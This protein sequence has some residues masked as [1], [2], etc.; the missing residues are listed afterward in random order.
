MLGYIL[1]GVVVLAALYL[2][3][4]YNAL[5]KNKS[6]SNQTRSTVPP[7]TS[8]PPPGEPGGRARR[9]PVRG[10][11]LLTVMAAAR[12]RRRSAGTA[13]ARGRPARR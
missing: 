6:Q 9:G 10:K 13:R 3:Y 2:V 7:G 11:L 8:G 12:L 5:V 4:A 1:L